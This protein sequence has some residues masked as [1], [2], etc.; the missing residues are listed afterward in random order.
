M[1]SKILLLNL[2]G[3]SAWQLALCASS[4]ARPGANNIQQTSNTIPTQAS[5]GI[6]VPNANNNNNQQ[7]QHHATV[8]N[9]QQQ[10][11]VMAARLEAPIANA[12][13]AS[14]PATPMANSIG[15]NLLIAGKAQPAILTASPTT[16]ANSG[17]SSNTN[18]Q[19]VQ[20]Q[21]SSNAN[22]N[23]QILQ[24]KYAA[25]MEL[26]ELSETIT[27]THKDIFIRMTLKMLI[28]I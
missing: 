21:L 17:S 11:P 2:I 4:N 13:V 10:Q 7:Q 9:Q 28:R 24:P 19:L 12:L 15:D 3:I 5:N 14:L 8:N 26:G 22:N 25:N 20:S 27:H 18:T 6:F 1:W 23:Q 16:S